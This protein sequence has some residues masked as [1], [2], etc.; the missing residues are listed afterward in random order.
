MVVQTGIDPATLEAST[1]RSTAELLNRWASYLSLFPDQTLPT[2][3]VRLEVGPIS[4][5]RLRSALTF[6]EMVMVQFPER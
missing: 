6:I 5:S 3:G 2:S 1:P 4:I